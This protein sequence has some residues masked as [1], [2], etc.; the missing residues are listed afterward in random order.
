MAEGALDGESELLSL[1]LGPTDNSLN[2]LNLLNTQLFLLAE[3]NIH[4]PGRTFF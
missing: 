2:L 3:E 1:S 4:F